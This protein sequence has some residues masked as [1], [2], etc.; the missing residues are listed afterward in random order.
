MYASIVIPVRN[1]ARQIE[2]CINALQ[3]QDFDRPYEI[4]VVDDG[5]TDNT[6]EVVSKITKAKIVKQQPSGPAKAR[7]NGA[8]IAK[9]NILLFIDSDCIAEK[10]WLKEM[11]RPFVDS[12]VS[13]VQGAYKT[14][15]K[16]LV[17]RFVQLEIEERY[18]KMLRSKEVDWIGT[19][20]AAYRREIFLQEGGFDERFTKASGEDPE[21]SYRI[22]KKGGKIIFNPKAIVH[23]TH[24][25]KISNYLKKKFQHA[26]WRILLY[27]LHKDKAIK[28]SYTPQ[29]LKAQIIFLGLAI[30]FG[31]SSFLEQR[32]LTASFFSFLAMI[33]AMLPFTLFAMK[34]DSLVGLVSP[35]FLFLRDMVFI[36]GLSLGIIKILFTQH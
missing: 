25:E 29:A 31:L 21:L 33:V 4:I 1:G 36:A 17:A 9:G 18:E 5:S 6:A 7:N 35:I 27:K 32:L 26:Y 22:Q 11:V 13:A 15:Q 3:K 34:R 28:D 30:F 14:K 24:P 20:S 2:T 16:S 12:K 10:N 19:Y 23:H 8:R